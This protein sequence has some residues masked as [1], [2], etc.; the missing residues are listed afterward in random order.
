LGIFGIGVLFAEMPARR[1][2][3]I[4]V[5]LHELAGKRLPAL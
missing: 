5:W 1:R 4:E 2:S 3:A